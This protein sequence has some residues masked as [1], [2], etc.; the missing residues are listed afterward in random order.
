VSRIERIAERLR[1]ALATT[2]A[3]VRPVGDHWVEISNSSAKAGR[4]I[5]VFARAEQLLRH[6]T[7]LDGRGGTAARELCQHST[8]S[9]TSCC[10]TLTAEF[11]NSISDRL[12]RWRNLRAARRNSI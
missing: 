8:R 2:E 5:D 12:G 4:R 9:G 1:E 7:W 6:V 10:S 11:S 3:S